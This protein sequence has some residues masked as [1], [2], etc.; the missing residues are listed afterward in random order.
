MRW[1]LGVLA[2]S[3]LGSCVAVP[4]PEDHAPRAVQ[5]IE[6]WGVRDGER[7]V[8]R[9]L[10][11]EIQ[12]ATEPVRMYQVQNERGQWLG[13]VDTEGRVFQRVPF[14]MTEEFRGIHPMQQGLALLYGEPRPERL[15][16]VSLR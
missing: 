7:L 5:E 10:L 1:I 16:V 8:G 11:L 15:D 3:F 2:V 14:S 13:Y 4:P 9:M 6:R 12:D